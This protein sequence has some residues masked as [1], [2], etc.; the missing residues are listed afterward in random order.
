MSG[1]GNEQDI[2]VLLGNYSLVRDRYHTDKVET[3]RK[4]TSRSL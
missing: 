2:L 3:L 4:L 1:T